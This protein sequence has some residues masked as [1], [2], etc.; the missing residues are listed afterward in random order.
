[1]KITTK[2]SYI[3]MTATLSA[4]SGAGTTTVIRKKPPL[5]LGATITKN[6]SMSSA[7]NV[8]GSKEKLTREEMVRFKMS[9]YLNIITYS[10]A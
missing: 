1:M 2:L 5:Q 8:G 4:T 7:N 3:C 6:P 9:L 10:N